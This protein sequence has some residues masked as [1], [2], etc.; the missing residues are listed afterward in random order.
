MIHAVHGD[1]KYST[2]NATVAA[3]G[4][5]GS[6]SSIPFRKF[7]VEY[8]WI[9]EADADSGWDTCNVRFVSFFGTIGACCT[10]TTT[11][12][13]TPPTTT[14]TTTTSALASSSYIDDGRDDGSAGR[15][16]RRYTTNE[17]T[18]HEA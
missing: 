7:D 9:N 16:G 14:S 15:G 11:A 12:T 18:L 10:G 8:I 17:Y 3:V 1:V 5:S 4:G 13:A 2:T 6:G